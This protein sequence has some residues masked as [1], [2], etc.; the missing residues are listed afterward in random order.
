MP[1]TDIRIRQAKP[2]GKPIKL[3]R[4][5]DARYLL[6]ALPAVREVVRTLDSRIPSKARRPVRN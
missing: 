4:G 3:A 6:E 5:G 1:L 2:A